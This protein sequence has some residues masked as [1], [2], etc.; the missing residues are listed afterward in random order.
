[1]CKRIFKLETIGI[2][3]VES[4]MKSEKHKSNATISNQK[5]TNFVASSTTV[6][7]SSATASPAAAS[8]T[9]TTSSTSLCSAFGGNDTLKAEV[10]WTRSITHTKIMMASGHFLQLSF[11]GSEVANT[12]SCGKDETSYLAKFGLA[13]YIKKQLVSQVFNDNFV[14]MF[15]ESLNETTK[16]KQLDVHVRFWVSHENGVHM[17]SR[18]LNSQFMGHSTTQDLLTHFKVGCISFFFNSSN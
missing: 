11:S 12:F 9:N 3:A 7:T 6:G 5:I 18:Y 4:Q 15:D 10:L 17:Q 1:M 14:L 2:G 13:P 16:N 8:T